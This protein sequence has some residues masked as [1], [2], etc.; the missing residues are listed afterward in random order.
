MLNVVVYRKSQK[1]FYGAQD[2]ADYDS[3]AEKARLW[4]EMDGVAGA[5]VTDSGTDETVATWIEGVMV[6]PLG[7]G[8]ET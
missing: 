8:A 7:T 1:A 5:Q 2:S 3:A 4:S 6:E